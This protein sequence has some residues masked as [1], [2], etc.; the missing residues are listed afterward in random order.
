M[1][2]LNGSKPVPN[3]GRKA[4]TYFER[5]LVLLEHV[6]MKLTERMLMEDTS[7]EMQEDVGGLMKQWD[8]AIAQLDYEDKI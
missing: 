1:S 4:K 8:K 7:E 5:R 3:H 2:R 6:L